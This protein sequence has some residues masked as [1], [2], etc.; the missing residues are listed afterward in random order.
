VPPLVGWVGTVVAAADRSSPP[1]GGLFS[2][3]W[4]PCRGGD[5]SLQPLGLDLYLRACVPAID[6]CCL[7]VVPLPRMVLEGPPPI[8]PCRGGHGLGQDVVP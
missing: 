3:T 1:A 6:G 5:P 8:P 2:S 4:R 7:G